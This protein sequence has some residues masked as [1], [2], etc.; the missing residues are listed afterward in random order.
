VRPRRFMRHTAGRRTIVTVMMITKTAVAAALLWILAGCGGNPPQDSAKQG[1]AANQRPQ[2][3]TTTHAPASLETPLPAESN[4][5]GDIPDTQAFVPYTSVAGGFKIDVPEGWARSLRGREARFTDKFDG[6]SIVASA[7]PA[8]VASIKDGVRAGGDF[9]FRS[10]E[11]PAG[12]ARVISYTSNSDPDAVTDK[13]V[14]L[15]N[16]AIVFSRGAKSV[17]VRL[18]APQGSDNVDQ[19]NRIERSFRWI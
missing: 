5:P 16:V 1:S 10:V 8:T 11:L 15:E 4:P 18:W 12:R 14:R 6:L 9:H 13:Q 17:T 2:K 19:W 3:G 7:S